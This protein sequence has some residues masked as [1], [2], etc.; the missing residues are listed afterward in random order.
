MRLEDLVILLNKQDFMKELPEGR[1]VLQRKASDAS[2]TFK[3]YKNYE[4]TLWFVFLKENK[5]IDLLKCVKIIK[6]TN[7][8][9]AEEIESL[10]LNFTSWLFKMLY[11]KEIT[12]L[13]L[14]GKKNDTDISTSK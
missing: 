4:I 7:G 14:G 1:F 13:I 10:E 3:A 8:F 6:M 5:K 11:S 9:E 2:E 12:S